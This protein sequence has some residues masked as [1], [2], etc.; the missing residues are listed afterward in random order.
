[1]DQLARG[2]HPGRTVESILKKLVARGRHATNICSRGATS[3][4]E[5]QQSNL[6]QKGTDAQICSA[7]LLPLSF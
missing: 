2:R 3:P 5:L 7:K 6:I 1:M 4:V